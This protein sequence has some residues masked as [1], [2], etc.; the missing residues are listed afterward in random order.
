[1]VTQN[2]YKEERHEQG[3]A[4]FCKRQ[5]VPLYHN[6]IL[7]PSLGTRG[8]GLAVRVFFTKNVHK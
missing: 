5:D 3:F 6:G 8:R 4:L 7:P 2:E 1:M